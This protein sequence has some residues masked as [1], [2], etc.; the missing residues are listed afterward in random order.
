[1]PFDKGAPAATVDFCTV[2][3]AGFASSK[4]VVN[5]QKQEPAHYVARKNT[6]PHYIWYHRASSV[7]SF[8][9]VCRALHYCQ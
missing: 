8:L 4:Q 5:T 2:Q 7:S 1:M 9:A 3:T 6:V